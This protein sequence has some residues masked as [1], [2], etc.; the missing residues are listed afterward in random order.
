MDNWI[1]LTTL[2]G[3]KVRIRASEENPK[4]GVHDFKH[5]GF[6]EDSE[7]LVCIRCKEQFI[8]ARRI[9]NSVSSS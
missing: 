8:Q 4:C 2:S 3:E 7:I 6:R 1:T 5:A 9:D